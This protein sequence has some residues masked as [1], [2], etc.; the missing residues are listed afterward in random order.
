[1]PK[2]SNSEEIIILKKKVAALEKAVYEAIMPKL[3]TPE[4]LDTHKSKL[5]TL[6]KNF[7]YKESLDAINLNT[8]KNDEGAREES[9]ENF[10]VSPL[11][12]NIENT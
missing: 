5:K 4:F 6:S 9:G 10:F 7:P 1:M 12:T 2:R 11:L 8:P 3:S